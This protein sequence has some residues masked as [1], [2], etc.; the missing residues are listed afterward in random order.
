MRR[1][2]ELERNN[3]IWSNIPYFE[4]RVVD[5]N[6]ITLLCREILGMSD[7]DAIMLLQSTGHD[8]R[9]VK[10]NNEEISYTKEVNDKRI[11]VAIEENVVTGIIG[12]F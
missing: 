4:G 11:N 7:I 1:K 6:D 12:I 10:E 9:I 2:Y 3:A 8:L 5:G